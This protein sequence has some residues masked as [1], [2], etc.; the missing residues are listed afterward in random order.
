VLARP[1]E[2]IT[3]TAFRALRA[4]G[5]ESL[6]IV[7]LHAYRAPELER[8]L[9]AWAHAE[10]FAHVALSHEVAAELGLL[11]RA[12]TTVVDAY[13][14]P[15]VGAY[16]RALLAELPG[17]RLRLMQSGG[18]LCDALAFRGRD[19]V[20]SGPAGGAVAVARIA[21]ELSLPQA[22]GLDMGGTSTD[23]CRFAGALERSYETKAAGVRLRA[24][25]VNVHTV[26]AGGGSICRLD[27][28]RLRVGPE[29][30]GATPGPLCYGHPDARALALTDVNVV[31]GRVLPDRFPF[32][33]HADRS[34][35]ALDAVAAQ[36]AAGSVG[37][38]ELATAI[39]VAQAFFELAIEHMAEAIAR[40]SI[41]RGHD[42]REHALIAFGGAAGQHACALARRLGIRTVVLHP[43]A[44]VLSAFGIGG[45]DVSWHGEQD[46][47]RR[48]LDDGD[49]LS[50][51]EL[52]VLDALAVRGR[53]EL[54]RAGEPP[55]R[56]R[57]LRRVDL[58]YRG[59][60]TSFT[61]ELGA[62][63]ALR[64]AFERIHARELGYAR[65]GHPI[66]LVT[67]RVEVIA[68]G[69]L[70]L[71]QP[72][73]TERG[74]GPLPSP[75]RTSTLHVGGAAH[76][77]P[78]YAREAL[79]PGHVLTG[80]AIVLEDTATSV[81]D[82]GFELCV[83]DSGAL[84][85]ADHAPTTRAPSASTEL[86]PVRLEVFANLFTSIAEQMGLVLQRS[87]LSTN[88]RE[89]LD[90]SCA[91]FDADGGLV[92]NAP[93]IPVHLGAMGETVKAMRVLHPHMQP[94]DAYA[95][96]APALGGSHLPD[97]TVVSP[98]FHAQ[99]LAFFVA[100]R[101]HHADI[102]GITPG[103]IPPFSTRLDEEGVVLHGLRVVRAGVFDE[104]ALRAALGSGAHPARN[105]DQNV[106]DL[107]AQLAANRKGE[108]LVAEAIGRHGAQV[109][110]AYMGHVQVD[111]A[112]RVRQAIAA[113]D[114]G[115]HGFRDTMDDGTVIAVRVAVRGD[116]LV[117]DFE[118]SSSEVPSNLNAPRAVTVAAVLYVLRALVGAPI[119]LNAGCLQPVT[120]RI[121]AGSVLD[122]GPQAAVVAGNVETSQRMVDVLLAALGKLAA[123]Q[124]TMNNLALGDASFG[125]YE[126]IC[127][128]AGAGPGHHG[129]SG[130][131]THM[132]NTR[133]TDPEVLE[134]SYP[135][136]LIRFELRRGSGGAGRFRGGDG[137]IRELLA[138]APL[139]ATIVSERRTTDPFGLAGG[140]PGARGRNLLDGREL[141]G[142]VAL[143]L[144][145]G[146]TLRIET[147]GGGGYGRAE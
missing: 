40:V 71:S 143:A 48:L 32:A 67:L 102:G 95:S 42:V 66:E 2:A 140:E 6:A 27:G 126:T 60:E 94:G 87:A 26:A 70:A 45:A 19:A 133:I 85:L 113:L 98:V 80:P 20:L 97:I 120:L 76:E 52:S 57:E 18:G 124:G 54:A 83:H 93:H 137:V 55:E 114:D 118:G 119:P 49:A 14:T 141:A 100:S 34:R 103:S 105:P 43:L 117:V 7:V 11:A 47:G 92:A 38:P 8:T 144:L 10:G 129:A 59:T 37:A 79:E 125:Y 89:R 121:P 9:G 41:G 130:V 139:S 91:L 28:L 138:L 107:Q 96:N 127:G 73:P 51:Q 5:I 88:I 145:P 115:E 74:P 72:P 16:V 122:P 44:G 86:D 108:A 82:P 77:V 90:F 131:H 63:V 64:E 81:L 56:H 23:V 101:G 13:L 112:L 3:R 75:L 128:G 33:L 25:M 12:E 68:R 36:L 109:V 116:K 142:R 136:R 84:V 110:T 78:V 1:Q 29:S 65:P 35:A 46:A 15:L 53:A 99:R 146:Q 69:E 147:P 62:G 30:A 123:C 17:S 104:A 22:I 24:P 39:H 132:T 31:L 134:A 50:A 106:A 4:R 58:R 111:A 21:R 135:L 61:V